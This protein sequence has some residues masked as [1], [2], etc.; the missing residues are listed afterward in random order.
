MIRNKK[1]KV[2]W[3]SEDISLLV[4]LTAKMVQL[5]HLSTFEEMVINYSFRKNAIGKPLPQ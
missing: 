4:W 3:N 5:S 2:N 1:V